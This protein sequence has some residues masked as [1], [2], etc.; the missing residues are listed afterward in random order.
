MAQ[1]PGGAGFAGH[2]SQCFKIIWRWGAGRR[3][4]ESREEVCKPGSL[5][6]ILR[7]SQAFKGDRDGRGERPETS[8]VHNVKTARAKAWKQRGA[9]RVRRRVQG[10]ALRLSSPSLVFSIHYMGL[11]FR[12]T[13][14]RAVIRNVIHSKFSQNGK[15][16][17]S[18]LWA[19]SVHIITASCRRH[20]P[21]LP[22][23]IRQGLCI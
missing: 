18:G 9:V 19:V 22:Q 17:R 21:V 13:Y 10:V 11:Q 5:N 1:G 15:G 16:N 3:K 7:Q 14:P 12:F 6:V 2:T 23:V 4:R 8:H 20:V